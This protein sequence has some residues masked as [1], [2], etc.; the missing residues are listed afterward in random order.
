MAEARKTRGGVKTRRYERPR[1][2]TVARVLEAL[3][4]EFLMQCRCGFGG[5]TRI[6][7][8]LDEYRESE[9]IDFL[10]SD[11]AGYRTL[12]GVIGD[13]SLGA[14]LPWL[15]LREMPH[16]LWGRIVF[17]VALGAYAISVLLA[18]AT[19]FPRLP[20]TGNSVLF[21]GDIAA[22]GSVMSILSPLSI[23]TTIGCRTN[24][25]KPVF[26]A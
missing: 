17:F 25:L 23:S 15:L 26:S 8:E 11:L 22:T 9:D 16:P 3:D 10:C 4:A 14:I 20:K 1:H 13:R 12:R 24:T 6:A 5:G 2:R 19:I 7:L 21:W 18:G